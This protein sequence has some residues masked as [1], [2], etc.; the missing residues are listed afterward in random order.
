MDGMQPLR[1]IL[2]NLIQKD[3]LSIETFSIATGI[4]EKSLSNFLNGNPLKFP[5]GKRIQ[6]MERINL[7]VGM[8]SE[9]MEL[10]QDDD[11]IKAIIEELNNTYKMNNKAISQYVGIS[12]EQLQNFINEPKNTSYETRYHIA[13]KAYALLCTFKF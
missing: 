2:N 12:E 1:D 9:G 11:R 4:E 3:K 10:V 5:I 7:V 6:I 8:L 13:A